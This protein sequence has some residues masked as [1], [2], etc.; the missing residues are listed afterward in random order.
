M[1]EEEI[2]VSWRAAV[3]PQDG[4]TPIYGRVSKVGR[5]QAVVKLEVNLHTG[6][7]CDLV[8]MPPKDTP[9]DAASFIEGRGEVKTCVHSA[10]HFHITIN[11]LEL[12][13]GSAALLEKQI[14][15]HARMWRQ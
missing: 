12:R 8:M 2:R 7:R 3:V 1:A 10:S 13:G 11:L 4:G 14:A 5:K 15:R 6:K 9:L